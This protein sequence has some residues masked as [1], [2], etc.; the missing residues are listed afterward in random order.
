MLAPAGFPDE[1]AL[2]K[3]VAEA[4]QIL[5]LAGSPRVIVV[6][7]EVTLGSGSADLLGIEPTGRLAIIEVKLAKNAEARRAVVAQ[8]LAYAAYLSGLDPTALQTDILGR[9][10]REREYES[11]AAA[12]AANDQDGSFELETFSSGL[13]ENLAQGRFR[14]VFVLDDA[15]DE[16]IRL[17]GYLQT[18]T[19]KLLIDLITVSAYQVEGSQIL[20]PQRVDPERRPLEAPVQTPRARAEGVYVDGAD[21]F[22]A[23]I[24][25]AREEHRPALSRLC[26]WAMSL[27][28]EGLARL[29]TYTGKGRLTLAPRLRLD[30]AGLVTIVNENG[31]P[32]FWMWRSVFERRAPKSIP[33]IEQITAPIPIGNG[34][35]VREVNDEL[36]ETLADAYR[37]AAGAGVAG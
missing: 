11:L 16:L 21:D 35:T 27:E 6:G 32:C 28:R 2:H 14:L 9:H 20:V 8:V 18:I 26:E 19:D 4:P 10:L 37:E 36:L 1:A 15:P 23:A 22:A 30:N 34:N 29:V 13:A 17:V 3:S 31:R 7:K 12:V 5:P 24:N 25:Q 33:R